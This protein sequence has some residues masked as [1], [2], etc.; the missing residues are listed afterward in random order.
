MTR[1]AIYIRVSTE[2]QIENYSIPTQKERLINYCKAKDW[3]ITNI[4][5]DPGFSGSNLQRPAIQQLISDVKEQKIDLVIVYKLDRL[6]RSQKDTLYLIED[7]FIKNNVDFVS[8]N[9]S[10][11]TTTSFGRAMIGILSVFAQLE[12]EQIRERTMMGRKARAKTG[13][14]HGGGFI[15]HGYDYID[16]RLV[17]NEYEAMQIKKI[18]ELYLRG[19]GIE[20]ITYIMNQSYS[21]KYANWANHTSITSVLTTP[22]YIG[23]I[24]YNNEIYDG[25]HEAIIDEET[26]EKVQAL[27]EERRRYNATNPFKPTTLLSGFI[28]CGKCGAR[29]YTKQNTGGLRYYTCYSRGKTKKYMIKDPNC[30]NKSWNVIDLDKRLEDTII[31]LAKNK[32]KIKDMFNMPQQKETDNSENIVTLKKRIRDI[33]KQITKLMN[34][35]QMESFPVDELND[36]IQKLYKEKQSLLTEIDCILSEQTVRTAYSSQALNIVQDLDT[37]WSH[38]TLEEKRAILMNLIK[39]ITL[40]GE[41]ICIEWTFI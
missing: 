1:T 39:K 13:L 41:D 38:A 18:Y 29:Y 23:K 12:R 28:W 11:D 30:K 37:I 35:Y 10:F 2:E 27:R 20:T 16:G 33:E 25:Q 14:F 5:V 32:E 31:D 21:N 4:Y 34:L 6:S 22:I 24:S 8:M 7:V 15:P 26:F 9:E 36:R 40:N 17:V 19:I 3:T